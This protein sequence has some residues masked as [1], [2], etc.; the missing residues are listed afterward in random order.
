MRG[1]FSGLQRQILDEN[2]YAFYIHCFA[3]QLQLVV[4]LVAN[5][6]F[7]IFDFF[8]TSTLIVTTVNY[9][10]KR[11]DQLSPKHHDDLCASIW[12]VVRFFQGEGKINK[13]IL[14]GLEILDGVHII[15]PYVVFFSCGMLF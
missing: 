5:C 4:V 6:C 3:Q 12:R 10:C 2:P 14:H 13:P 7:S 9:S 1:E 8:Q 15:K 11:R